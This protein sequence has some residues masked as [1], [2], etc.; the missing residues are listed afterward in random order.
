MLN[1]LG[2]IPERE[3]LLIEEGA[4]L[5]DYGKQEREG[6]KVGHVTIV[7]ESA[8]TSAEIAKR[9]EQVIG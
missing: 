8:E 4:H 2:R 1:L 6:R 3:Q 7:T 5:H 9:L